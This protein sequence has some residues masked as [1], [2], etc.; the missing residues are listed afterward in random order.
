MTTRCIIR[1]VL[2]LHAAVMLAAC[3]GGGGGGAASED[4]ENGGGTGF[5]SLPPASTLAA[6]CAAPRSGID[7]YT[8]GAYADRQ[9]SLLDEQNWLAAWTND[10]YLWYDEVPYPTPAS[11]SDAPGYFNA[12]KTPNL[13]PS[14][15]PKDKFHFTYATAV[16]EALS[17]SGTQAGYGA[18]WSLLSSTPPRK[19][20]VAYTDPNTPATHLSQPLARG[21]MVL[22]VDGVD[23]VNDATQAGV[24]I[25]NAGLFPATVGEAHTFVVQDLGSSG[26]RTITMISASVTSAPV[27]NVGTLGGGAVGYM[28]FNDHLATAEQALISAVTQ[29][30]TAGVSDLVLDIRYNGGGY[31]AVAS[32][33]AY[34]IAGPAQTAGKTFELLT[35]NA[36]H[37]SIDP[38]AL[39]PIT[40][41]PF[42][43][44]ALGLSAVV[45]TPLPYLNLPRV[46]VLTGPNTCSASESVMNS[47]RGV[48]VQVI[49]IGSTTCGKPY[50]FYPADNCGTSYFSIQFKGVNAAGFGDYS[51]G[52][53]AQ[54]SA[55][56]GSL[57][58]GAVL[59]GCSVG[60][61]FS[62]TLG[63]ASEARV[64]AALQYRASGTCP[65]S[66][67][68][69]ALA[70]V[71][72]P[73]VTDG[74]VYK[75][76]FLS[77]RILAR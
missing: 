18:T 28:L 44:T 13:S 16:W 33:L 11:Y 40:P 73:S 35:F 5:A 47:L 49:Q 46:Y 38:V 64:A 61:D 9:G 20:V 45:G 36:K 74:Q 12:L 3:G 59:P 63:A 56:A 57:A 10:L 52:F 72:Q 27:Q 68:V 62:H 22:R 29:L 60:D 4:P 6:R 76:P 43:S 21:A 26:T 66:S 75:G 53:A 51:D 17:S 65:A 19:A 30:K 77:N 1:W 31:L 58:A 25:L 71:K 42:Q 15:A 37:P 39:T 67:G 34:M 7:P 41:M 23:L 54:N 50:G 2:A 8:G 32:E 14:G 24:K 69:T 48:G 70:Q 55:A